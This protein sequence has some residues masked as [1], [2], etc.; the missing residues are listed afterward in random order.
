MSH[1]SQTPALTSI[2]YEFEI[3][4]EAPKE[5]VWKALTEDIHAWW[6]P[7]FHMV[8]ADSKIQLDAVAGGQL[9]ESKADGSSLLWYTVQMCDTGNSLH[10]AGFIFPQ[11]GGPGTTLL[12]LSLE[13]VEGGTNFKVQDAQ[14]GAIQ[15][16]AAKSMEDGWKWLFT[17][18]LKKHAES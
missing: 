18:G 6:L 2:Q 11:W 4:I 13:S 8:G 3:H 17:D 12:H 16:S 14:F 10:L 5:K 9:I 15:A 1:A 7:D